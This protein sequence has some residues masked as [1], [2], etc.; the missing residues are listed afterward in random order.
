MH[1]D[2]NFNRRKGDLEISHF[3]TSV[4]PGGLSFSGP[5]AAPGNPNQFSGGLAGS[6]IVGVASGTFVSNGNTPAAGVIGN[7]SGAGIVNQR[8][9][10]ATGIFAGVGGV[11]VP[12]GD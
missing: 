9:Y 8:A 7:W 11:A 5:I 6:G 10:Q 12:H 4:K 3:D 2:W 1:M